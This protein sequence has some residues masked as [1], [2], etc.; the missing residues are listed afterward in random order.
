[1]EIFAHPWITKLSIPDLL[2]KKLIPPHKP[3]LLVYNFDD[4]EY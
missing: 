1:M 4:T 3:D 2:N